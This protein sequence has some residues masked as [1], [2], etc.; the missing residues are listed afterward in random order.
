[1]AA[2]FTAGNSSS[3][4]PGVKNTQGGRAYTMRGEPATFVVQNGGQGPKG[5]NTMTGM[6]GYIKTKQ[7]K[8]SAGLAKPRNA[9]GRQNDGPRREGYIP[10]RKGEPRKNWQSA[11]AAT[12]GSQDVKYRDT[13]FS[14]P[15]TI[16]VLGEPKA[17]AKRGNAEGETK[18]RT[19]GGNRRAVSQ[20][21]ETGASRLP[22]GGA[23]RF[24]SH[25]GAHTRGGKGSATASGQKAAARGGFRTDGRMPSHTGNKAPPTA[26]G[27]IGGGR[28]TMESL[29]GR[30]R[31]S[32]NMGTGGKRGGSQMY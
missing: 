1:M 30:V 19:A 15:G 26:S 28:G 3:N 21:G 7:D 29:R 27:F 20:G 24:G 13:S 16:R 31:T 11:D 8:S 2:R 23:G 10:D 4:Q 32:S 9:R 18:S 17:P 12:R 22:P 6:P 25:E 14:T 5:G